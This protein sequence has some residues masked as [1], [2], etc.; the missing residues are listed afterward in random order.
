MIKKLTHTH[1]LCSIP[2]TRLH[3]QPQNIA[4]AVYETV[5]GGCLAGEETT[6]GTY[7]SKLTQQVVAPHNEVGSCTAFSHIY[8]DSG[9]WGVGGSVSPP[10]LPAYIDKVAAALSSPVSAE[11]VGYVHLLILILIIKF[12]LFEIILQIIILDDDVE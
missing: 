7:L 6:S 11:E 10:F 3:L 2:R 9:I 8:S 5:L 1:T 4:L 12:S